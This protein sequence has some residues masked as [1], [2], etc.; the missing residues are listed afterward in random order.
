MTFTVTSSLVGDVSTAAHS[1]NIIE[2][3]SGVSLNAGIDYAGGSPC[4]R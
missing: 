4:T 1:Y 3:V 2:P